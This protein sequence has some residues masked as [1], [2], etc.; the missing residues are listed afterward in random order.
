MGRLFGTDGARGIANT[1][2]SCELAA[3]IGRAAAMIIEEEKGK[4]PL[5]II[6]KDTRISGDMLDCAITA[7]LCSAG[8][9]VI[10]LGVVPTPAVAYLV[11]QLGADAGVMIS[12]SHNPAEFNGI[13]LFGSSGFK[14]TDEE[15][16]EIE[17][18]VLDNAI[19][20]TVKWGGHVGRVTEDHQAVQQYIRHVVST[21]EGDLTGLRVAIDC[22]NGSASATAKALFEELGAECTILHSS[23]DG[24]NINQDCG[25]T[26]MGRL[27]KLVQAG[28]FDAGLA[29]DGDADR[30]L[31][32]DEKGNA[33]S[34]DQMIAILAHWLREQGR[35][36]NDAVVVTVM[37]N[38]GFFEFAREQGISAEATKVG[39]RYVLERMLEKGH[40]IGGEQ[41]G[42]I[43][44][45]E[46]MTTGDGQL[47]AVQLLGVM[48]KT[49]RPLSELVG[50]MNEYPQVLVN[51]RADTYMKCNW[52][53]DEG[54]S[55]CIAH[56]NDQLAGDGRILVRASGTEPLIRI[57]VEGKSHQQISDMAN[58]IADTIRN[59]LEQ[60]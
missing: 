44:F 33:V 34:G 46:H 53:L 5:F 42:H 9:D 59:R 48:K 6:G 30:C 57:M 28:G 24:V 58:L 11:Q 3:N 7:G 20:Y 18:I 8:A 15:E 60:K 37:S 54:V 22:A 35:L 51:L 56:C 40:I 13:K 14:L 52:E 23:P 19:P 21:L 10:R 2:I 45:L 31:V 27:A 47:T 38:F 17:S 36:K 12:A 39:D 1:E 55:K 16:Y 41:S 4:R 50:V 32:V 43:I 29:F 26:H 49:G 25:S